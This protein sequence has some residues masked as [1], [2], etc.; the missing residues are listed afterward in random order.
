[1]PRKSITAGDEEKEVVCA[2]ARAGLSAALDNPADGL[3]LAEWKHYQQNG[4]F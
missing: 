4:K 2:I 1:M 3:M